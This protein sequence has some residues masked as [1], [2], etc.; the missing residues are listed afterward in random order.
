MAKRQNNKQDQIEHVID[1]NKGRWIDAIELEAQQREYGRKIGRNVKGFGN[2]INNN[3][4]NSSANYTNRLYNDKK[5]GLNNMM[6]YDAETDSYYIYRD[7]ERPGGYSPRRSDSDDKGYWPGYVEHYGNKIKG[8][9]RGIGGGSRSYGGGFDFKSFIFSPLGLVLL[10]IA[11]CVILFE[12][13]G[14]AVYSFIMDGPFFKILLII[15]AIAAVMAIV[16]SSNNWPSG[17]KF[18]V[19]LV[20]G[21]V[22]L[23]SIVGPA[24]YSFLMSGALFKIICLVI[25]GA[26]V[27]GILKAD[28]G[29]PIGIKIVV[30]LVIW[31]VIKSEVL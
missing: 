22:L 24:V 18:V 25:A 4:I 15:L 29:W 30:I 14:P 27:I 5:T 21:L 19:L 31:L 2:D 9:F 8:V 13:V 16:R 10:V 26:A 28:L 20:I 23:Y 12:L 11:V 17:V 6:E 3:D 7:D 1:K